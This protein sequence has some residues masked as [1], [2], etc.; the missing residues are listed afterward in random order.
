MKKILFFII[1]LFIILI[2]ILLFNV[3]NFEQKEIISLKISK[4]WWPASDTFQLGISEYEESNDYINTTFIQKD[5]INSAL[6]EFLNGNAD[7]TALTIYEM[8]IAKSRG[9]PIKIVLLLD[10]TIGSDG[11][12]AKNNINSIV[13]LKGKKIGVEKGTISHFT[14]LKALEKAGL[15]QTEVELIYLN[16]NELIDAFMNN[17]IDAAG[18]YEPYMSELVSKGNGNIIFSS[19]EIPRAICDVLFVK[20]SIVKNN[21]D[22]IE[23]W[24]NIW[25]KILLLK[26][27][28]NQEYMELL[29]EISNIQIEE[30][31]ELLEGI[32]FTSLAENRI[33]FGTKENPGYLIESIKEMENF[34]I[35]ENIIQEHGILDDLI[36]YDGI[37]R[38]YSK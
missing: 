1:P 20:E 30:L 33:A 35:Q 34:L 27:R 31:G 32:Y 9:L 28:N 36:Y 6:N 25:N 23:H 37:N 29:S 4:N 15:E 7:G 17:K 5:N 22:A 26:E 24:L 8:L 2:I 12:V 21:P 11:I 14:V 16:L 3:F 38:F 18:I 19:E 10:Y 13:E